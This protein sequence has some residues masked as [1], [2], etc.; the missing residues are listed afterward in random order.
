MDTLLTLLKI[1]GGC[2]HATK[3]FQTICYY[4]FLKFRFYKLYFIVIL[5]IIINFSV[6]DLVSNWQLYTHLVYS[7]LDKINKRIIFD[8]LNVG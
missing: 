6:T 1:I 3:T 4:K 7:R 5:F 8:K 2:G